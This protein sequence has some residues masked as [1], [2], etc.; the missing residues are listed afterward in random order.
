MARRLLARKH[1]G[2]R[3]F[4]RRIAGEEMHALDQRVGGDDEGPC[5]E[6]RGV[7]RAMRGGK[8]LRRPFLDIRDRVRFSAGGEQGLLSIAFPP[9]YAKSKRVYAYYTNRNC[10]RDRNGCDI[11]VAES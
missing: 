9:N 7:V 2:A 10:N 8:K 11:E 6:Q 3:E 1:V 5:V 4:D